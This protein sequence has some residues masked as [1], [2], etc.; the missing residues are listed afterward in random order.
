MSALTDEN[1]LLRATLE[2]VIS[3]L[4]A[5]DYGW[6]APNNQYAHWWSLRSQ[7]PVVRGGPCAT[8]VEAAMEAEK[9]RKETDHA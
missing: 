4:I 3:G 9:A 8:A 1:A 6:D 2:D 7:D 5:T